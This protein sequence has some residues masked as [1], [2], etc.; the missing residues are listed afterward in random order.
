MALVVVVGGNGVVVVA[1]V[2]CVVVVCLESSVKRKC[3]Q[4][5]KPFHDVHTRFSF[6]LFESLE[7]CLLLENDE[8]TISGIKY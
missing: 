7:R 6:Y 5:S 8:I 3:C 4:S 2:A 1:V